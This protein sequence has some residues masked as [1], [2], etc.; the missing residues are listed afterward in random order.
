MSVTGRKKVATTMY[1][2]AR[3]VESL[4]RINAETRV[5]MAE[6]MRQALNFWL[7]HS[8][9]HPAPFGGAP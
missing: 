6:L 3:Q 4:R 5:P 7:S 8:D 2:D 1:L 9:K